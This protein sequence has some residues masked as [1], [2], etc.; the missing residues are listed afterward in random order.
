MA[1]IAVVGVGPGGKEHLTPAAARAVAEADVLVGGERSLALFRGHP[2]ELFTIKNNL[3]EMIEFIKVRQEEKKIAV[4]ASGDPGMF[5]ILQYLRKHFTPG[6]LQVI[7]GISSVQYACARLAVPWQDAVVVSTHG[8]D[9]TL[10][11]EAVAGKGK[12]IVLAGPEEPPPVLAKVLVKAGIEDKTV[13]VCS[14]LSYPAEEIKAFTLHELAL[15]EGQWDKKN[16]IMVILNEQP[17]DLPDT[18][19]K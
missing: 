2:G 13:Y 17:M 6:Q 14:E 10:L 8:R 4:I 19:N 7:P 18:R 3:P 9:R 5:G 11:A 1:K 16:Y 12:V 15:W